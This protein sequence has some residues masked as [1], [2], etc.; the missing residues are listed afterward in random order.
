MSIG[1]AHRIDVFSSAEQTANDWL[2]TVARH[3]G[4]DDQR[5]AYRIVRAWLQTVRNRLTVETA[6][7]LA[8]QL[9]V[10]W[11]GVFYDGWLPER[12]PMKFGADE[13]LMT[14]AQDAG[15]SLAE[16]REAAPAM[17]AALAE[18]TSSDEI[19][20]VMAALPS[21]LR[22]ILAAGQATPE[23]IP[24]P[25]PSKADAT[26]RRGGSHS[27][28]PEVTARVARL[29]R[30]V[31]IVSDALQAL[32]EALDQPPSSEPQP[33]RYVSGARQAHQILLTRP[34]PG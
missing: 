29:E 24:E 27:G 25:E 15:I 33:D 1:G 19:G 17:T 3:L 28:D 2:A 16:A 11:R 7:H 22:N 18:L 31:Q 26:R 9:P 12:M 21:H 32:V 34:S 5:R 30:D 20:H 10:I 4:T 13:L 14:L 6:A 23:Q 8:A